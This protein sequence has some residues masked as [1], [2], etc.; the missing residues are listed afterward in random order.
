[1]GI[2][3]QGILGGFSGKVANV[4]GSSWKGIAVIKSLPISVANPRTAPQVAQ[5]DRFS[6][7]VNFGVSILAEV[8]K[9]LWD[10]FAIRQSGFNA[11]I[12]RNIELFDSTFPNPPENLAIADG[13]MA[14]T[15][16]DSVT[17]NA[18]ADT[19]EVS[20]DDDTGVGLKLADDEAYVVAVN[21]TTGDIRG[22][23]TGRGRSQESTGTQDMPTI[24]AG[25]EFDIYL[26]FRRA[27]GTVVSRTSHSED[28]V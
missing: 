27:D 1:M 8:I 7:T 18:A 11:F 20:W 23:A 14:S 3:R 25:D 21:R 12:S 4:V 24:T 13:A 17:I 16:I 19:V 28:Q 15:P 26:A 10:R 6:N 2:I 9:P 5:R 22:F